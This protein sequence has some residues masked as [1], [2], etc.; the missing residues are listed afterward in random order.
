MPGTTKIGMVFGVIGIVFMIAPVIKE[1]VM[2]KSAANA[3]TTAAAIIS[4]STTP[5]NVTTTVVPTT[6]QLVDAGSF[7]Y[8]LCIPVK[9]LLAGLFALILAP[10]LW[11][12]VAG[13][14]YNIFIKS[15]FV[16]T[17]RISRLME[18]F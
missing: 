11:G 18:N 2:C 12:G 9:D 7:A 10:M 16:H 8:S 1:S 4:N 3:A 15:Q 5:L 14:V 6:V 13:T 17:D